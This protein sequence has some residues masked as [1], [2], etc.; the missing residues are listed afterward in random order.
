[1]IRHPEQKKKYKFTTLILLVVT[2]FFLSRYSMLNEAPPRQ[3]LP[4]SVDVVVVGSGLTGNLAAIA[5]AQEGVQVLYINLST[6][7]TVKELPY[8]TVFWAADTHYQEKKELK[9]LPETMALHLYRRGKE[10]GNYAQLLALSLASADSLQWLEELTGQKFSELSGENIGMHWPAGENAYFKILE[11]TEAVLPA[12]V[13]EKVNCLPINLITAGEDIVG[14]TIRN[15]EGIEEEIRTRAV[16]LADGGYASNKEMLSAYAGVS[17]VRTRN[18]GGYMGIGLKLAQMVGAQTADLEKIILQPIVVSSGESVGSFTLENTLLVSA[19][20][21][22]INNEGDI[23]ELL[24]NNGE[25]LFVVTGKNH[26]LKQQIRMESFSERQELAAVLHLPLSALEENFSGLQPPYQVAVLGLVAITPGGIAVTEDYKVIGREKIIAGLYAAG[27][28]TAGLHGNAT[29][30]D[31]FFT[32][33][34][35][36]ARIAGLQ[37]AKYARR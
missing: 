10:K 22:I 23:E 35:I 12:L 19:E 32:E 11:Q 20:G 16:I 24:A 5:A 29:A 2:I 9:Y 31:L 17:S 36:S 13:T 34:V 18:S 27:E 3:N 33:A 28:I 1:M 21:E 7:E 4:Q 26:P 37:A 25:T 6:D 15:E 30:T 8:P 14:L